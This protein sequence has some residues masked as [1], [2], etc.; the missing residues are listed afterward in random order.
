MLG[1]NA[2]HAADAI[3]LRIQVWVIEGE[4]PGDNPGAAIGTVQKA[5]Y[6]M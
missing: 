5:R 2:R 6:V 4:H 1:A 3:D